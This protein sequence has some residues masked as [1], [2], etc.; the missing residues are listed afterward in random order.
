VKARRDDPR[1]SGRHHD[2]TAAAA[3][4]DGRADACEPIPGALVGMEH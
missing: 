2:I 4:Q 1:V 3:D